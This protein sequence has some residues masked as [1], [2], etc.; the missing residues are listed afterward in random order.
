MTLKPLL[1]YLLRSYDIFSSEKQ[2]PYNHITPVHLWCFSILSTI[3]CPRFSSYRE[4]VKRLA[5]LVL[6]INSIC[7]G[8]QHYWC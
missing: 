7:A 4:D 5:R 1:D 8:L 6:T 2:S 3:H